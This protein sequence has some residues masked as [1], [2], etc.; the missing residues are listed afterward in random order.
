MDSSPLPTNLRILSWNTNGLTGMKPELE[1]ILSRHDIDVAAIQETNLTPAHQISFQQ[2]HIIRTDVQENPHHSTALLIKK[3]LRFHTEYHINTQHIHNTSATIY[4]K[5]NGNI[6]VRCVYKRPGAPVLEEDV[7]ALISGE[8]KIVLIGDLNSKNVNWNSRLTNTF[9]RRLE[10]FTE[11]RNATVVAPNTPTHYPDNPENRP[12]VIDVAVLKFISHNHDIS[13]LNEGPKSHNPILLQL[14]SL[15]QHQ[16]TLDTIKLVHYENLSHILKHTITVPT[17]IT[18]REEVDLAVQQ[19]ETDILNSIGTCTE[20]KTKLPN[21]PLHTSLPPHIRDLITQRNRAKRLYQRTHYPPHKRAVNN[22][23][24][25]IK[26]LL[27][28]L[29]NARWED[30]IRSLDVEDQSLWRM[31]KSL[32]NKRPTPAPIHGTQGLVFTDEDKAEAFADTYERNARLVYDPDIDPDHEEA[33]E[34]INRDLRRSQN[35]D[36]PIDPVT[37]REVRSI[38]KNL[39]PKS[40][41]GPDNISNRVLKHLPRKGIVAITNISNAIMRLGYFPSRWKEAIVIMIPKPGKNHIFPQNHRPI[42]LL[43]SLAKVVERLI[44]ARLLKHT[45]QLNVI[46]NVQFGFRSNHSSEQQILRITELITEGLN[47]RDVTGLVLFDV[48]QAF[49][50]VWCDGLLFKMLHLNY[51]TNLLKLIKSYLSRRKIKV[52]VNSHLSTSRT[53]EAGVPQGAVLS[54]HLFSIFTHDIPSYPRTTLA[55]YADD[56]AIA[57]SSR[58]PV[59]VTRRLQEATDNLVEYCTTWKIQ[60]NPQK[61]QAILFRRRRLQPHNHITLNNHN[62]PW[63]DE[64][65]Y[66]GITFDRSLT[67]KPHITKTRQ[68]A[69]AAHKSL[70]PLL[71]RHSQLNTRNKLLLY[72]STIQPIMSYASV[73]WGYAARS[74]INTLQS[75]ENR[76]IRNAV[77]A[78]WYVRNSQIRREFKIS[79]FQTVIKDRAKKLYLIAE[80]H[81][82]PLIREASDYDPGIP[83]SHKRPKIQILDP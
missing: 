69:T 64:V 16:P 75:F 7:D 4:T 10:Q 11:A 38:I 53:L 8:R 59:L 71:G 32:R 83:R 1:I 43:N 52:R 40:A 47:H 20:T 39:K 27:R 73:A 70:L 74:H 6:T 17:N 25:Q 18:T 34:N 35:L 63:S 5:H 67:W 45:E 50:R 3:S 60:I 29:Y 78:P 82:N 56:T 62:I 44:L 28:E 65:K 15:R 13:T 23:N 33:V 37:H 80:N 81:D 30:K 55:L 66:L 2:Y 72:K 41:P 54:P 26:T 22:L 76:I 9:G 79:D 48:E 77:N 36:L 31:S 21:K 42:S 51:P 14:T 58:S 46:P 68:K 12:D 57:T 61:T 24:A 49:D 19:L